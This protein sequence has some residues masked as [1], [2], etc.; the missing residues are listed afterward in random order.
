MHIGYYKEYSPCLERDMEF[1]VYG[2][3]G[4][5]FLVFPSQNGRFYEFEDFQMVATIQ[6]ELEDGKVQLFCLDS[7][8]LET[9]SDAQGDESYR[10]WKHEQWYYYICNELVPRIHQIRFEMG[11]EDGSRIMTTGCSMGATHAMNFFLRRPDLFAGTVAMSGVYHAGMFFPHYTDPRVYQ[12]SPLDYLP[13]MPWDH[14]WLDQYRQSHI[15]FSSGQGAW[16]HEMLPDAR[17]LKQ[18]FDALQVPCWYDEWGLDV[19]HD[20]P[21]WRKQFPYFVSS[22]ID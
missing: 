9:W 17:A 2:H 1:K 12:N 18:R 21:W 6:K 16:E 14:P 7:I 11:A 4:M 19:A 20:W 15:I 3:A 5:P 8:D 13:S 22:L 10:I